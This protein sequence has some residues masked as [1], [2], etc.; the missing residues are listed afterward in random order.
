M[1]K[2]LLRIFPFLI[3][4]VSCQQ[5]PTTHNSFSSSTDT[6]LITT[7]KQKGVGVFGESSGP[8][9]TRDTSGSFITTIVYPPGLEDL[10]RV[11]WFVDY[12]NRYYHEY[13]RGKEFF[14]DRLLADIEKN[15]IDT[16][17][18]LPE[19]ENVIN[20]VEGYADGRKVIIVDENNNK[21]LADDSVRIFDEIEW[22]NPEHFVEVR[23][24]FL[25]G[26]EITEE[27]S[28]INFRR[29]GD[30][31]E[32]DIGKFEHV[33]ADFHV[34]D[35]PFRIAAI[36]IGGGFSYDQHSPLR[37]LFVLL[38]EKEEREALNP[39]EYLQLG[40]FVKLDDQ[41]YC[42]KDISRNGGRLT[43]VREDDF[44]SQ[45][46]IQVGMLAPE[47]QCVTENGDT[48]HSRDLKGKGII[49]VNMC[50]CSGNNGVFKAYEDIL[51]KYGESHHVLGV[52]SN[53][54]PHTTGTLI[55]SEN[56]FNG[57]FSVNYR[58]AYCSYTTY[59][60]NKEF[61]IDNKFTTM[62]WRDFL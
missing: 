40:Q 56:P 30:N 7:T 53:F 17:M 33:V 37:L 48:L 32:L 15:R 6:L 54:G 49:V 42:I 51:T 29:L 12:K 59:I 1:R 52:D 26:N 39:S 22:L 8:L 38:D 41:Y 24:P 34:D 27:V 5:N 50:G 16:S 46:G 35:K 58:Q 47:F 60:I 28:W 14:L 2:Q 55:N 21:D 36:N 43:L 62:N 13:K 10:K 9:S 61:R 44:P 23:F 45:V 3:L 25:N 20:I 31:E 4:F 18:F 11:E 57:K 19:S